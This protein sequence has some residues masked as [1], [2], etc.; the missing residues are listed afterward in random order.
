MQKELFQ[1]DRE[2]VHPLS[3]IF[4]TWSDGGL[5]YLLAQESKTV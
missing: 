1:N 4:K 3:R 2:T 5:R